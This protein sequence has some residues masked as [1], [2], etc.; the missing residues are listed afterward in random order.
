MLMTPVYLETSALETVRAISDLLAG[1]SLP[2]AR[3]VG[4]SSM[5]LEF[6]NDSST[7]GLA[8]LDANSGT[9]LSV[10]G[11]AEAVGNPGNTSAASV[12]Q[13]AE[14]S[15]DMRRFTISPREHL[16]LDEHRL[17][18]HLSRQPASPAHRRDSIR[19]SAAR[20]SAGGK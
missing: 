8:A 17:Q 20:G 7:S 19:G 1:S 10:M 13:A 3:P 4:S 16:G 2:T 9:W 14:A 6:A 12:A 18:H 11:L 15:I 5:L